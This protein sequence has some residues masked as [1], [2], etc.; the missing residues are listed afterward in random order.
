MFCNVMFCNVMLCYVVL[1]YVMLCYAMLCYVMLRYLTLLNLVLSCVSC[2]LCY[3]IF[4]L[5]YATPRHAT[6]HHMKEL[7]NSFHLNGRTLGF[8]PL[9]NMWTSRRLPD[10]T[11]TK[12]WITCTS[13]QVLICFVCV[14]SGTWTL[15]SE[16][17]VCWDWSA[18]LCVATTA[19]SE[20]IQRICDC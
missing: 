7:F 2:V 20:R 16:A 3:A 19:L 10:H 8:H 1:C 18:G 5:C 11:P 17:T 15:L 4:M 6:P 13:Y 9:E 14:G 12:H